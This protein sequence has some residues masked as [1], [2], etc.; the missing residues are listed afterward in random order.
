[1]FEAAH[2]AGPYWIVWLSGHRFSRSHPPVFYQSER[3]ARA[4]VY[5]LNRQEA[6]CNTA[7]L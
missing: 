2:W 6:P 3:T 1:M 5:F 4:L 7:T